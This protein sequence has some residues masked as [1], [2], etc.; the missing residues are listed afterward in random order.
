MRLLDWHNILICKRHKTN[1]LL[2]TKKTIMKK[3]PLALALILAAG[4]FASC[5]NNDSTSSTTTTSDTSTNMSDNTA[6]MDTANNMNNN[7][8]GTTTM[9]STP[10]NAA[11]R[12]FVMKAAMGGMMEVQAANIILKN[13]TNDRVK[14]FASMMV[15]DH[16]N[17]NNELKSLASAKGLTIPEDSLNAKNKAHMDAMEKMQ[18]KALDKHYIDMMLN[19]HK[20]DVAEFEKESTSANDADLKNWA[21]KT[22]PTL[23]MHLDSVQAISKDKM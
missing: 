11:D 14:N 5:G 20:K 18:G 8:M 3:N 16:S 2:L 12:G 4:I 9:S 23:K 6:N 21:G 22:L 17:A 15:R 10:L 13:S 7:N 1:Q 19:D